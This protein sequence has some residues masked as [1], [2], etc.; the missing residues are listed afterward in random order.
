MVKAKAENM[1]FGKRW[2]WAVVGALIA[3][4]VALAVSSRTFPIFSLFGLTSTPCHCAKVDSSPCFVFF[5][6]KL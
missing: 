2:S 5:L 3:I 4:F 1:G 6:W